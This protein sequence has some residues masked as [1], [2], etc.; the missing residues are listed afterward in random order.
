M[1]FTPFSL[2]PC[3]YDY[4]QFVRSGDRRSEVFLSTS[5]TSCYASIENHFTVKAPVDNHTYHLQAHT[6]DLAL[7]FKDLLIDFLKGTGISCPNLFTQAEVHFNDADM[8]L[9]YKESY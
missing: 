4:G 9:I 8:D 2:D 1:I 7:T 3:A 5:S 6:G